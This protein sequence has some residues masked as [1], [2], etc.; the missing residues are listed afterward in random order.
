MTRKRPASL[1]IFGSQVSTGTGPCGPCTH[2]GPSARLPINLLTPP[3]REVEQ[4]R[5]HVD[6]DWLRGDAVDDDLEL[7]R[8][9]VRLRV[10][11]RLPR[12]A[13]YGIAVRPWCDLRSS[14]FAV[15]VRLVGGDFRALLGGRA[16]RRT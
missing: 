5:S 11:R 12:V 8:G 14:G 4:E 3:R 7:D 9:I 15:A 1:P 16:R 10:S 6:L 2:N 13:A